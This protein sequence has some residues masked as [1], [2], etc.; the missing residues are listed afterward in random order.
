MN[1]SP[2]ICQSQPVK[3][4]KEGR[5]I[6]NILKDFDFKNCKAWISLSSQFSSGIRHPELLSIAYVLIRALELPDITRSEK[7]SF[8]CLVK[9]F[10]DNWDKI[11]GPIQCITLLDDREIPISCQREYLELYK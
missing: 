3:K 8:P 4:G 10:N 7:R 6:A 1:T 11:S 9:W 5:I 2:E